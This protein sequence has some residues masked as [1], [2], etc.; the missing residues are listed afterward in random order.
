MDDETRGT[1]QYSYHADGDG[2]ATTAVTPPPATPPTPPPDAVVED[3]TPPDPY[4]RSADPAKAIEKKLTFGGQPIEEDSGEGQAGTA[5]ATAANPPGTAPVPGEDPSPDPLA[6]ITDIKSIINHPVFGPQLQSWADSSASK[7]IRT[8][9]DQAR[10]GWEADAHI[11]A[12]SKRF[13]ALSPEELG[14]TLQDP[15][16][17][18]A[19]SALIER[20]NKQLEDESTGEVARVAQ[21]FGYAVQVKANMELLGGSDLPAEAKATLAPENFQHLGPAGVATWTA[22][23][24]K[25]LAAHEGDKS[26]QSLLEKKWEAFKEERMGKG[27]GAR[28]TNGSADIATTRVKGPITRES[29]AGMTPQQ[30]LELPEDQVNAAL[31]APYK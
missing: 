10:S 22:E 16:M 4:A 20:R 28:R 19:Y 13:D 6:T 9:L 31:A 7:A 14:R 26:A 21:V 17:S 2:T 15:E 1:I 8:A 29:L 27:D 3:T 5:A 30:I 23:I 11:E 25:A 18:K 12:L 24:Q